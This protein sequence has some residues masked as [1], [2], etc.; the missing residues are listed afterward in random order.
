M[1]IVALVEAPNL[2]IV[3]VIDADEAAEEIF[4][5]QTGQLSS[6]DINFL[7]GVPRSEDAVRS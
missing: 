7:L 6:A 4:V 2:K 3:E 1:R 5:P